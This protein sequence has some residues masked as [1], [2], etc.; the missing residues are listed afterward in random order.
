MQS[1]TDTQYNAEIINR[2]N[3]LMPDTKPVWGKMS[4]AQMMAHCVEA[5]RSAYGETKLKRVLMGRLFGKMAKKSIV[6]D[7]P[8]KHGLPTDKSFVIKE[9]KNFEEEKSKLIGYVKKYNTELLTK[10][11]HPFFGDMSTN[12]WDRLTAKH[13]DHHLRQFGV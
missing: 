9:N 5:M 10:N 3:S 12:E 6:S 11:S 8:F 4:S 7:K 13:L 2:I 1:L